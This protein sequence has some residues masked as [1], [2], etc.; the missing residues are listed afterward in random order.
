MLPP[1]AQNASRDLLHKAQEEASSHMALSKAPR[2]YLGTMTFGWNQAS[3]VV[4][5]AI[6]CEMVKKF[7]SK[8]GKHVDTARIYAGGDTE[9]LVGMSIS[10][11]HDKVV[12]GTKAAPS[13]AGGLSPAGIQAQLD[14]STKA[15]NV[16]T[17][18]EYYLHQ[19]D[20][21]NSLL[22]SL[23]KAHELVQLGKI[24][25]IGLSNYHA[26]EVKR[27]FELCEKHGLTKP[28]VYQG[29][30][31]PLNRAVEESLMPTLRQHGCSFIAYN[32]L[33]AG[34]L[35][36]KHVNPSE[37]M[38]GRFKDN[39][40]YL[41]RFYTPQCFAALEGIRNACEATGI[42]MVDAAY[43]WLLLHSHLRPDD[44]LLVGASSMEQLDQNLNACCITVGDT[45]PPAVLEA[46]DAA[47]HIT[48]E[49]AFDY[50]RSY[51]SDMPGRDQRP[52]GAGY[53][54]HGP[55]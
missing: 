44:G 14:A 47:W 28:T 5:S 7:I 50:F 17:L 45:L 27:C 40:N 37:V 25:T 9:P 22:E 24:Q 51:S 10:G 54:A 32:P 53:V 3:S 26:E 35:T 23:K 30:Y 48:K 46:M 1:H 8:G 11:F 34:L 33:A 55:K 21:E 19:P 16:Q 6:A 2:I 31:N 43:R 52:Q 38:T 15:L 20:T 42:T 39:P 13:Q 12:L 36:G 18:G 49:G 41:P 4:D 29:L